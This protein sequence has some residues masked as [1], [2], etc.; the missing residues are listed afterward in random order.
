MAADDGCAAGRGEPTLPAVAARRKRD[1]EPAGPGRRPRAGTRSTALIPVRVT[2]EEHELFTGTAR[3]RGVVLSD[4]I[5]DYL[6]RWAAQ[7]R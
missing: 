4:V 2:P 6:R 1:E 7:S 3:R 5:R